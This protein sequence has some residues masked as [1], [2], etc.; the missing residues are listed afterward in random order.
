MRIEPSV[1]GKRNK[2]RF[3][4]HAPF[5]AARLLLLLA[6]FVQMLSS[7]PASKAQED[8]DG[9]AKDV[10]SQALVCQIEP[11]AEALS[12][13]LLLGLSADALSASSLAVI[14]LDQ[15][16]VTDVSSAAP[17]L[18]VPSSGFAGFS[19]DGTQIG[20]TIRAGLEK[21]TV[22]A[23]WDGENIVPLPDTAGFEF[24]D[25]R[26]ATILLFNSDGRIEL[27][28]TTQIAASPA[29]PS[30]VITSGKAVKKITP[31]RKTKRITLSTPARL[32]D[33]RLAPDL[34]QVLFATTKFWPGS[35]TCIRTLDSNVDSCPLSGS[36]SFNHARWNKAGTLI[37]YTVG[38]G[39]SASVGIFDRKTKTRVTLAESDDR[40][41]DPLWNP[42][43]EGVVYINES[44]GK[45]RVV[46]RE[47]GKVAV[48]LATC[49]QTV[50]AFDWSPTK[51]IEVEAL[52]VKR[53]QAEKAITA[54]PAAPISAAP[55]SASNKQ[56]VLP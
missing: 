54:N 30:S 13:R 32:Q 17:S 36:L 25:W 16:R 24:G 26:G 11:F 43:G 5:S 56:Q 44:E 7:A 34:S 51:T 35:D 41:F 6:V 28:D 47:Q 9:G 31:E 46:F 2:A 52:R 19:P 40:S 8:N 39:T 20:L 55:I 49:N 53:S 42:T 48:L 50:R 27:L 14:D 3:L 1:V 33:V 4:R 29:S 18:L 12:G 22:R 37:A 38:D 45:F 10:T 23:D 21:V 15:K